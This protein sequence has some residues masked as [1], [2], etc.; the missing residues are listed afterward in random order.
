MSRSNFIKLSNMIINKNN[1]SNIFIHSNKYDIYTRLNNISGFIFWGCGFVSSGN[2]EKIN[3]C[4]EKNAEDY[5]IIT[6]WIKD[7]FNKSSYD[8]YK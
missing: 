6:K 7:E 5:K 1:I 2:N 3:I 4:A 8:D